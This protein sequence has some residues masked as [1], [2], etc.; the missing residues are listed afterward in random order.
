[1]NPFTGKW[2]ITEM[3]QWDQSFVD[4][5]VEGHFTFREGG[6]SFFQ[7]GLVRGFMDC[8]Y[9]TDLKSP[10]MEF[11]WEGSDEMDPASGSGR[12]E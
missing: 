11:T 10:S 5:E 3:S 6:G 4:M 8:H 9:S 1:M 7:F 12:I 2:R